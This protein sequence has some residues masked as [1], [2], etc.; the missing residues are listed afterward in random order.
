M[1]L[2]SFQKQI[3]HAL[4]FDPALASKKKKSP[5]KADK[6][7]DKALTL[8]NDAYK[9][10]KGE[11]GSDVTEVKIAIDKIPE[12]HA[13]ASTKEEELSTISYKP[14]RV[15]HLI[16]DMSCCPYVDNDGAQ[17]IKK[18]WGT[19]KKVDIQVYVACCC[20]KFRFH[21]SIS[22]LFE[23]PFIYVIPT[24][25]CNETFTRVSNVFN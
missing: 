7:S 10:D 21:M 9:E 23:I 14:R 1:V 19:L 6:K 16:L 4:G 18:V 25:G 15:S 11:D 8:R 17:I 13:T 12:S 22:F 24:I 3:S 20:G 2:C 5:K